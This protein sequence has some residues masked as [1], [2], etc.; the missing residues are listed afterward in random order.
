M[1]CDLEGYAP[2]AHEL[3]FTCTKV[4]NP[5]IFQPL[6]ICHVVTRSQIRQAALSRLCR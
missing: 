6:D 1:F 3:I 5:E 2:P 4:A